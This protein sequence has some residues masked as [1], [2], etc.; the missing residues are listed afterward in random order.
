MSEAREPLSP[1]DRAAI[2]ALLR[3]RIVPG[4]PDKRFVRGLASI[5]V[6]SQDVTAKQAAHL[7]RLVHRFR[8]QIGRQRAAAPILAE[9]A[10]RRA[11]S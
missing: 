2:E 7:W 8:G 11:I 10:R 1:L 5:A 3:V 4:S 9:A 6:N